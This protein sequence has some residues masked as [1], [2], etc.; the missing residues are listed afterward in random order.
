MFG[1][2]IRPFGSSADAD[3]AQREVERVM[4]DRARAWDVFVEY[5]DRSPW[6]LAKAQLGGPLSM[7]AVSYMQ[8]ELDRRRLHKERM[9]SL[10]KD[11]ENAQR[12][13]EIPAADAA[14]NS[15]VG[16]GA[17]RGP[18]EPE[19]ADRGS[20]AGQGPGADR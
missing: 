4:Q 16:P 3:E 1:R 18:A 10:A 7:E 6:A 14:A 20:G 2:L 5:H 17:I 11:Q 19:T 15:G 13:T 8:H 12:G 9:E